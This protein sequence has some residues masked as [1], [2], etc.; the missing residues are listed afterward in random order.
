LR[1][2]IGV[3][4]EGAKRSGGSALQWIEDDQ[5]CG[6][7]LAAG[8]GHD[9]QARP[10][11]ALVTKQSSL[12]TAAFGGQ[13]PGLLLRTGEHT[14]NPADP[15]QLGRRFIAQHPGKRSV[16]G[17]ESAV[18][19]EEAESYRSIIDEGAQQRLGSAEGVLYPTAGDND[20]LEIQDLL[21][22]A[23]QLVDQLL[24]RAVIV[25]HGNM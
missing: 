24:L 8:S 23:S 16:G 19:P 13:Q 10:R 3:M 5:N 12:A 1:L 25:A 2:R 22:Q 11:A 18:A 6:T 4:Q 17:E 20:V 9:L 14:Q 15:L 21:A 7:M